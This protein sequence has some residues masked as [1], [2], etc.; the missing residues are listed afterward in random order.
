MTYVTF[1]TR[2]S[3]RRALLFIAV[4]FAVAG[5]TET[6][7]VSGPGV[8]T[9][10]LD[11]PNGSEGAALVILTGDGIG[12]VT[13]VGATDVHVRAGTT[14]TQIVL[15][16]QVG[17][18]LQFEVALADTTQLPQVAIQEVAGPDDELRSSLI[19]YVVEFGG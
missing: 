17:G 12:D 3:R 16:N 5:C 13:S 18:L 14:G 4:A 10:T 15:I 8:L 9:A 1:S 11:S 2:W 19:G 7:P 6:G